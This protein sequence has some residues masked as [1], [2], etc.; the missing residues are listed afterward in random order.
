MDQIKSGSDIDIGDLFFED[1]YPDVFQVTGFGT[2]GSITA[3]EVG[4]MGKD[5]FV[6][7]EKPSRTVNFSGMGG[8]YGPILYPYTK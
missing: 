4:T 7:Y 2:D 1:C 3:E 5:G 8:A 6:A